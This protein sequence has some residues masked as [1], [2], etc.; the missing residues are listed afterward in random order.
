MEQALTPRDL[1]IVTGARLVQN[2]AYRIIYP[3]TPF[4]AI[5]LGVN[6]QTVSLLITIQVAASLLSPLG[7]A[8]AARFG[9]RA[10]M[11]IGLLFFIFGSGLCAVSPN[12]VGFFVGYAAIG[13]SASLYQPSAQAYL[14]ART[15][16]ERRGRTLGLYEFAWAGAALIGVAPLMVFVGQTK[17]PA[18]VF[19]ILAVAGIAALGLIRLMLPSIHVVGAPT[20]RFAWRALRVPQ[21]AALLAMLVLTLFG[22]DL[23]FVVQGAWLTT[24][25]AANETAV[26]AVSALLGVAEVI[27][28]LGSAAIVDR[29][30]KRRSVRAWL[31]CAGDSRSVTANYFPA[32]GCCF[33]PVFFLV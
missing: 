24:S 15:S 33:L 12:F 13:I 1:A 29:F 25:F 3:I 8:I 4:L 27:G 11:S 17:Q 5:A 30:G 2:I 22:I 14:S 31:R 26:G 32:I 28:S 20:E 19:G 7:G 9:Q 10:A 21:V 23:V 16:Y 6:L 18:L